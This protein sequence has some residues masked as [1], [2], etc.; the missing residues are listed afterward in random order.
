MPVNNDDANSKG[1][2][3]YIWGPNWKPS[4]FSMFLKLPVKFIDNWSRN[5]QVYKK[6]YR[7]VFWIMRNLYAWTKLRA[8]AVTKAA[9][10]KLI[11]F[12]LLAIAQSNSPH[13]LY[14]VFSGIIPL[15][16]QAAFSRL[17]IFVKYRL[18]VWIACYFTVFMIL[19]TSFQN[20]S[21]TLSQNAIIEAI[22]AGTYFLKQFLKKTPGTEKH[23]D[24]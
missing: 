24:K 7:A 16:H 14:A 15:W 9:E 13:F 10:C 11:K 17:V 4:L 6:I 5:C 12:F 23:K 18:I 21:K 19:K 2:I 3:G 8:E 20:I 22:M 1:K